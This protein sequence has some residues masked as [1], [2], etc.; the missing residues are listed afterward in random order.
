MPLY[1]WAENAAAAWEK[2]WA[3]VMS[4]EMAATIWQ[5]LVRQ[6]LVW[7]EP[8]AAA[9]RREEPAASQRKSGGSSMPLSRKTGLPSGGQRGVVFGNQQYVFAMV[10]ALDNKVRFELCSQRSNLGDEGWNDFLSLL[11]GRNAASFGAEQQALCFGYQ[12][13]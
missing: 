6:A 10:W 4:G 7:A 13:I 1:A 12:R 3:A 11:P 5:V 2:R 9:W 8:A